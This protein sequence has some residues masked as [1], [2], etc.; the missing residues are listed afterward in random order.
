MRLSARR[1]RQPASLL[2]TLVTAACLSS[3]IPA[4][5]ADAQ[6]A[7]GTVSG[8]VTDDGGRPLPDALVILD[9]AGTPRQ[10]TTGADGRF[11]FSRVSRGRHELRVLR[12]RF[13]AHER[14]I[15]LGAQGLDIAVALQPV[16][17]SLDTL[18]VIAR[19]TGVFG[20]VIDR[21]RFQP[22]AAARVTVVGTRN[23]MVTGSDGR[24][25]LPMVPEGGHVLHVKQ[26]AFQPRLFSVITRA[27]SAI[28][29]AVLL[30]SLS[31]SGGRRFAMPFAEFEQRGRW[32]GALSA[33]VPGRELA[34]HEDQALG[35]ALRYSLSF[36]RKGLLIDD[37]VTCLYVNGLPRPLSV[38]NDFAAGDVEAVEVY[39]QNADVTQTLARR[40]PRGAICGNPNVPRR[41]HGRN[42]AS[43]VVIWLK[44]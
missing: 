38:V 43:A 16:S 13:Q 8:V 27:D 5:R 23:T 40:W 20:T 39:G 9:P 25:D 32:M 24:F 34:G 42:V 36:L 18:R 19:R 31:A 29:V 30:D 15:E 14:T 11:R 1:V 35:D 3:V 6:A 22:L 21:A 44:R 7:P 10:A 41:Y 37:R 26:G 4:A 2:R 33:L 17:A 28:E 12:L